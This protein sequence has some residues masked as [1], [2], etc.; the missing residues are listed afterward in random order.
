MQQYPTQPST[1]NLH[2]LT[3]NLYQLIKHETMKIPQ[4]NTPT[5]TLLE[6]L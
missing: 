2:G 5:N 3:Y 4:P 1:P 6:E